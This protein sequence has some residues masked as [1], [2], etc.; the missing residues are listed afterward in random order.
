[1]NHE[2]SQYF[3]ESGT[4]FVIVGTGGESIQGVDG[5][6][7]LASIYEGFGCLDV[8]IDGKSLS[9]EFYSYDGNTMNHFAIIK[10]QNSHENFDT[11]E[12]LHQIEYTKP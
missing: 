8:Q 12:S 2:Q 1:M 11:K 4:I 10:D 6:P 7:Y 5:K 3:N 9:A